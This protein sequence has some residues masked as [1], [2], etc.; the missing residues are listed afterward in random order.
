MQNQ[1]WISLNGTEV[2]IYSPQEAADYCGGPDGA[3]SVGTI[4]RW[5]NTGWLR[6]LPFGR[7]YYY[8]LDALNECLRLR[9]LG[10]RIA[11][12]EEHSD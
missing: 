6:S 8:T 2:R 9:K 10:N 3:V 7:G 12:E 1:I 5:R 11:I 4:N